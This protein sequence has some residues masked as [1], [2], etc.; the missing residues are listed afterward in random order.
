MAE[1]MVVELCVAAFA[2][3]RAMHRL[4]C[5]IDGPLRAVK[6][7]RHQPADYAALLAGTRSRGERCSQTLPTSRGDQQVMQG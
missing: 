4:I 5:L 2:D 6:G 3:W 7:S 1:L